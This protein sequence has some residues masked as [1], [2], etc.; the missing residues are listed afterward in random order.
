M[1]LLHCN[2]FIIHSSSLD[3]GYT[4]IDAGFSSCNLVTNHSS[5][6][7]GGYASIDVATKL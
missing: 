4:S 6:L 3:G 5:S 2:L 1:R 7:E